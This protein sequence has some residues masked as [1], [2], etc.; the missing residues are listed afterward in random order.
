M[1]QKYNTQELTAA[2]GWVENEFGEVLWIFRLGMWDLPKG[3]L[4]DNE[5]I[6]NCAIREVKEECGLLEIILHDKIIETI[7]SYEFKGKMIEKTTHWYKMKVK[8]RP[9]LNPQK[10]EDIEYAVWL[11][12]K[13]W[14]GKLKSTYSSIKQVASFALK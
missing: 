5:D 13:Q 14:V 10:E 12:E 6:H 3:K 4:E 9:K 11:S 1:S 7:H 2:G 8:G